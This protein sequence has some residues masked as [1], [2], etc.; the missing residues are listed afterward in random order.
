MWAAAATRNAAAMVKG[1]IAKGAAVNA[2]ARFNDWPSQITSEPRGQYHAYGGLTP[3]LHAARGGCYAC[4]EALVGAGAEVNLPTPEG[5]SPIMVALDNGHNGI[6]KFLMERGG[7]PHVGCAW[8]H[9]ALSRSA[10]R[11]AAVLADAAARRRAGT[12]PVGAAWRCPPGPA[13]SGRGGTGGGARRSGWS[14][15]PVGG[16]AGPRTADRRFLPWR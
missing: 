6:A 12:V 16:A 9:G 11:A 13:R 8:T 4:V 7:N 1:L 3:L 5:V 15:A 14:G 10:M 2:R